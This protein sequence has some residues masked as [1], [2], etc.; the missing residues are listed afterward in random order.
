MKDMTLCHKDTSYSADS[1]EFCPRPGFHHI[2]ACGTYQ[3]EAPNG[4]NDHAEVSIEEE[5]PAS[6]LA[7]HKRLGRCIVYAWNEDLGSLSVSAPLD[8]A[9]SANHHSDPSFGHRTELH[10]FDQ[11]AI[12]DMKWSV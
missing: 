9:L 4:S 7:P 6:S 1:V 10:A 3:L 5:D 8:F 2:L 11:P 12:L